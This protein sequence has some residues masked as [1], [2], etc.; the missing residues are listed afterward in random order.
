MIGQTVAELLDGHVGLDI[1]GID[2][3]YLNLYQP[4]LQTGGGVVG[5][6]KGHRGAQVASTTLMAPM[7]RDFAAAVQAFAKRDGVAIVH[8]G[9]GQRKDDETQ[10]RLKDFDASEGVLYIGVA[11][12]RCSTFRVTKRFSERTGTSFPWLYRSSV[13][14]HHYYFYLV[15]ADFGPLFLKFSGYFPYTARAC[16]NGHEYAKCQL[17][18]EGIAFEAL[19]N[20]VHRCDDPRRLQQI[21]DTLDVARIDAVVRKWLARLPQPFTDAD[22]AAGYDY[23]ISI[24]Q[25]EFARTQVFDRPLSG[26]H[27]FEEIIRENLDLGRPDQVSLIF[28]RR[29]TRRTPGRFRTRVITHGVTPSLHSDYKATRIKQYFKEERALRTETTINNTRDFGLG[30]RLCNLPALRAIGFAANR[31]VLEVERISQDCHLAESVFEQVNSPRVVDGQRAAALPFG[32]PRV[33]ALLQALCL[34]VLLPEGFRNAALRGHVAEL[35]GIPLEAYTPGRMTY[36]L[37]RLRLHGLIVRIPRTQRY[38]ITHLGKRVAVFFTKLNARVLRPGLSQLFDGCP[39]APNRPLADAAKR[40]DVAFDNL[41]T[42]AKL[43][44]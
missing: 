37:R 22:R 32:N 9:K 19:D 18:R 3:L 27:L 25:A 35:L 33:M 41:I 26:R 1:E 2:R 14:C 16:L 43:A 20:G 8:F 13:M 24:L 31:R 28:D 5:F 23:D 7:T 42:E 6:F 15:D 12:E 21:A 30:R 4:R 40:L 39:K 11:Q 10:R 36:D 38:E 44:A 29:I 17:R 34:F